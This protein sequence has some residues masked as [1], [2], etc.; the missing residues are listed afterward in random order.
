MS[1]PLHAPLT[2]PSRTT[3]LAVARFT[4]V[5]D[6]WPKSAPTTW[7]RFTAQLQ[8]HDRR[9]HK[10]GPLFSPCAY[11]FGAR[12]AAANVSRLSMLVVDFDGAVPDFGFLEAQRLTY[13]AYT[14]YSH[15]LEGEA[16]PVPG[17]RWRVALPLA[18]DVSGPEWPGVN[19]RAL[20]LFPGADPSCKDAGRMYFYP[21]CPLSPPVEPE[22]RVRTT[23]LSLV[24]ANLPPLPPAGR[25]QKASA[26]RWAAQLLRD[27]APQGSRNAGC[28]RLAAFCHHF[29][30]P[31][32]VVVAICLAF[33]ERCRP[34]L[35][36]DEVRTVVANVCDRY[37][38]DQDVSW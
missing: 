17:P 18:A 22:V 26:V 32:D 28:F 6:T 12:R 7:E 29:A 25:S 2:A 5:K 20:P 30:L 27:G 35:G 34:P 16:H 37:Q 31:Q 36:E 10:D 24:P 14:T 3:L 21:A 23:G 1:S 4:D 8:P 15:Y 11:P 13:A 19:A 9:P 33:A 38:P